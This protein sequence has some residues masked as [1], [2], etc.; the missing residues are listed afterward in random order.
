[1][2]LYGR[3]LDFAYFNDDPTGHFAWMEGKTIVDFFLSSANYGYYRPVVFTVLRTTETLF[4]GHV[5]AADH[6]LL[7]LLHGANAAMVWLLAYQ[8]SARQAAYAWAAS[9]VFIAFPFNYEAVTYVASLTH[10][11]LLFW[12]LIT[13]HLY[14]W[15]RTADRVG[16][17]IAAWLTLVLALL[18]HENGLMALPALAG[19]E[20]LLFRPVTWRMWL[21][22]LGPYVIPVA[23]YIPLWLAIPKDSE[24][25]GVS[26][27]VA[28]SNSVPFLQSLIYPVLPLLHL[29]AH[30]TGLLA[31]MAL[32]FLG[33]T[34]TLAWRSGAW[35]LWVFGVAWVVIS[36]LPAM[37]FLSPD[38]L[39]GSPR[40]SYVLSVGVGLLW[41][42]PVLWLWRG[43]AFVALDNGVWRVVRLVASAGLA[44][45][46]VLPT[47]SF[48]RCQLDFYAT[49]SAIVR[50]M[51]QTAAGSPSGEPLTLVNVPFFFSSTIDH[52]DGCPSPYPWTPVGA[53][54]VPPYAQARD[55]VR[56]NGGPDRAMT[57]VSYAGYAPGWKTAGEPVTDDDLRALAAAGHVQVFDLLRGDFSDLRAR[58]Q[59]RQ[60]DLSPALASFDA[61]LD[62]VAATIAYGATPPLTVELQWR[63][64]QPPPG[65]LAVFV[66]LY[67]PDGTLLAQADGAPGGGFVP[68]A[69][70]QP[71]D[72]ITDTFV[73]DGDVASLPL[74]SYRVRVGAYDP[75]TGERLPATANGRPV[76]D[77]AFEIGRI[78]KME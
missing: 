40:L 58:W 75:A 60:M 5:P 76:P 70:W 32:L 43:P 4:S 59:P 2:A 66:H 48:I 21:R 6:A 54:V 13:L 56:F 52:P 49:A 47:L 17:L 45:L 30:E 34:G 50:N 69:L 28:S 61:A 41:G 37:L 57:A 27:G 25:A 64:D 22:P 36:A 9:L 51:A 18:T 78:D 23:L 11:L 73:L 65:P 33:T 62:L 16:L 31:L 12:L 10:P 19:V 8:L 44:L 38:Y 72:T 74:G 63:V 24:A 14:S 46:M 26:V 55:F 71:G 68:V 20:W 3:A 15:G 67:G 53:V 39:Y 1:M 35:R 42:M 29:E 77:A 7:L